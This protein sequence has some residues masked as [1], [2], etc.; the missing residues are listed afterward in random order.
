MTSLSLFDKRQRYTVIEVALYAV[1]S[2]KGSAVCVI[3]TRYW[4][5]NDLESLYNSEEIL[6]E[7]GT[8]FFR[9]A[10]CFK[11]CNM[12]YL[13]NIHYGIFYKLSPIRFTL[14][15]ELASLA[16]VYPKVSISQCAQIERC[17]C[18]T[19]IQRSEINFVS[20]IFDLRVGSEGK[21][22][23]GLMLGEGVYLY[24]LTWV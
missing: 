15:I 14:V 5:G 12:Y 2:L 3:L 21:R 11:I 17:K 1:F 18:F 9:Q 20:F 23:F 4:Q 6:F 24:Q 22:L 8:Y 13:R 19:E 16:T 7:G 10:F